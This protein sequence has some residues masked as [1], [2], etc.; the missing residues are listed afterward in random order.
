MYEQKMKELGKDI[1]VHWFETGHMGGFA[2]T[3]LGIAHQEMFMR[4]AVEIMR[5]KEVS[6][7]S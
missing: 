2:D 4:F 5:N 3:E 6:R 1:T 7:N